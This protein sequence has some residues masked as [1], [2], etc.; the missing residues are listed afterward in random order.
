MIYVYKVENENEEF[1]NFK[2]ISF[3][4]KDNMQYR[5]TAT[6]KIDLACSLYFKLIV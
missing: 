5:Y 3:F 1:R 2:N 6:W 4:P